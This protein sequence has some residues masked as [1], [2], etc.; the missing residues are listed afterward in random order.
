MET[1]ILEYIWVG[2]NT[3]LRSK[4][5]VL[6]CDSEN[7]VSFNSS[8]GNFVDFDTDKDFILP[9]WNFDGSSTWQA[10]GEDSEVILK[11]Y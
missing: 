1:L 3:E 10:T 11:P 8:T 4:T 5:K 7:R 9:D 2:G 6:K